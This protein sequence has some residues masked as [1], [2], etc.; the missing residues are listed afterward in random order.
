MCRLWTS[1]DRSLRSLE[2]GVWSLE[3]GVSGV[4][5]VMSDELRRLAVDLRGSTAG[6]I[7]I[8]MAYQLEL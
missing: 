2:T 3:T 6:G 1:G 8:S 4:S 5:G 7:G